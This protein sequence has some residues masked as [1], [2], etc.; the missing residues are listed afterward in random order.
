M[1]RNAPIDELLY[2]DALRRQ[3]KSKD[4]LYTQSSEATK[5]EKPINLTNEKYAAQKFIREYFGVLEKLGINLSIHYQV[6]YLMFNNILKV[7]GFL[8]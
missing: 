4:V 1:S 5:Y 6:D 3:E 8:K 7:M 2:G